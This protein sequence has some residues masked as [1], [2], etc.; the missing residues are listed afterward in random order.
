MKQLVGVGRLTVEIVAQCP[1]EAV[2]CNESVFDCQTLILV[3]GEGAAFD[4]DKVALIDTD[5][6]E[7][8]ELG[9]QENFIYFWDRTLRQTSEGWT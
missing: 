7:S 9:E 8:L 5:R 6:A 3:D 1:N 2:E 4:V